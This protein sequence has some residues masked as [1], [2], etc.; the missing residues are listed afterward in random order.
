MPKPNKSSASSGT[1]KK[2]ANKTGKNQEDVPDRPL[3]RGQKKL[4]KAQRKALPQVKQYIPPPKPPAPPIPDPLDGQ[5]LARTLPAELV[6]VLRRLGKKD[7][8]TR[9]K[10]LEDLRQ[11]WVSQVIRR[12]DEDDQVERDIKEKALLAAVPVWMHNLASLLQSPFHRTS[13][14]QLHGELLSIVSIRTAIIDTLNLGLLPSTQN[15]DVVGSWMVAALEEGRRAG[16]AA[17]RT[18]QSCISWTGEENNGRLD[19]SAY[20]QN[21]S[22]FLS[23]SILNPPSLHDDIHPVP[24]ASTSGTFIPEPKGKTAKGKIATRSPQLEVEESTEDTELLAERWTRYRIGGLVGLAWLIQQLFAL[25]SSLPSEFN[26]LLKKE[27]LWSSLASSSDLDSGLLGQGQPAVRRAAYTLLDTVVDFYPEVVADKDV[28]RVLS[29]MVLGHCWDESEAT[30]WESAG[31]AVV[32]FLSSAQRTSLSDSR[33]NGDSPEDLAS[34]NDDGEEED[35]QKSETTPEDRQLVDQRGSPQTTLTRF[36]HYISTICP[37]LPH[38]CYPLL[39]VIISTLPPSFL[40]LEG[41]PSDELKSLFSHLWSPVDARLLSTTSIG[42]QFSAFQAFFRDVVDITSF[43]VSKALKTDNGAHSVDWLVTE[44]FGLR[45]WKEGVLDMGGKAVRRGTSGE[46]EATIFSQALSRLVVTSEDCAR[47]VMEVVSETLVAMCLGETAVESEKALMVLP[48][49]LPLL[50]ILKE[51]HTGDIVAKM[52]DETI[53]SLASGSLER[54]LSISVEKPKLATTYTTF[55]VEVLRTHPALV[56]EGTRHSLADMLSNDPQKILPLIS[57][58]LLTALYEATSRNTDSTTSH[59]IQEAFIALMT[60]SD[61]PEEKRFAM[62]KSV[63]YLDDYLLSLAGSM[64]VLVEKAT[65]AALSIPTR[66]SV[67]SELVVQYVKRPGLLSDE[68][69]ATVL[70]LVCTHI[71]NAVSALLVGNSTAFFP[72]AALSIFV[73]YAEDHMETVFDSDIQRPALIACHHL[74]HLGPYLPVSSDLPASID[75]RGMTASLDSEDQMV[76]IRTVLSSFASMIGQ[77]ECC[78]K[79]EVLVDVA[80]SPILNIALPVTQVAEALLPSDLLAQSRKYTS[81]P[82]KSMLP[83]LDPLVPYDAESGYVL[84]SPFDSE[85][86]TS[87]VRFVKALFSLLREDRQLV[88]YQ[89]WLLRVILEAWI[90]SQDASAVHDASRSLYSPDVSTGV[91]KDIVRESEGALSFVLADNDFPNWSSLT[92]S[93]LK[94]GKGTPTTLQWLLGNLQQDIIST[95]G[96]VPSRIFR[97]VLGR[98]LRHAGLSQEEHG[99]WLSYAVGNAKKNPQLAMAIIFAAKPFLLENK[100]FALAQNRFANAVTA[101]RGKDIDPAGMW[102]LRLLLSTAPPPDA[103]AVFLPQ[104]RALFVLRH[105]DLWMAEDEEDNLPYGGDWLIGELYRAVMPIIQDIPGKHWSNIFNRIDSCLGDRLM[106]HDFSFCHIYQGLVLVQQLRDLCETNKSLRDIW[107]EKDH[108]MNLVLERFIDFKPLSLTS[109]PFKMIQDVMLDLLSDVQVSVRNG[110]S[111]SDLC[112]V[113]SSNSSP[114]AQ[115]IAYRILSEVIKEKTINLVLQV[116]VSVAEAQD[117]HI[118]QSINLPQELITLVGSGVRT[119]WYTASIPSILGQLLA[120]MAILD[121]F[122]DASRTLRWAYLDQLNS[123]DL[124]ANSLL[125]MLFTMLGVSEVGSWNF[126]ASQYSVDEFH[127][128]LFDPEELSDLTPL[129]SHLYYRSLVTLPSAMRSYYESL[130]DRQLSMSMLAFTARH[131]SSIIIQHEFSALRSPTAMSQLTDEGLSIR[132]AQGGGTSVSG[133]SGAAEAIASYVVDEQPMEIG[134]RLPAEF[135]LKGVEVRDLRRVGVPENKWRGWLMSNGLMLEALTVFKKNV[136]LHFEGVVECAICYSTVSSE[137]I[138]LGKS[139]GR[140]TGK[141][142]LG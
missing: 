112:D 75:I 128:D 98:Q 100:A 84:D 86:Q 137:P 32:K 116:E 9:R 124:L 18:W 55:L 131:Y 140:D 13:T 87:I 96:D 91:L 43:L 5:G 107:Q 10:G 60:S 23:Q 110:A 79:P 38:L 24:I 117:G 70:A 90:I 61:L 39:L 73:A 132:I 115:C 62:A 92:I 1:R 48:R 105:V 26:T 28:L 94:T 118:T 72:V 142:R 56:T 30:V 66:I 15:R 45:I 122:D 35:D 25:K 133:T 54:L 68:A 83:V 135:P 114:V 129:A 136:A 63:L 127:L 102:A 16:G 37:T 40:P 33:Q 88:K 120:W 22:E 36:F 77:V 65:Q 69:I 12:V 58:D 101:I 53:S 111:V 8:V 85:G 78:I 76:F 14:L 126:P 42:S 104:K 74:V 103:A 57:T 2:H 113:I 67:P 109:K 134:I 47:K 108:H 49:A 4:S 97:D 21:L 3:Q 130:K 20:L 29:S 34:E 17:L 44:Q 11:G 19:L 41:E 52:V 7:D 81:S 50:S 6:V 139:E 106:E 141:H 95:S 46:A 71:Q 119:D 27:D 138:D 31:P 93:Y 82:P 59:S 89:P 64:D 125:P 80:L 51:G 121:H 99:Q 123:S